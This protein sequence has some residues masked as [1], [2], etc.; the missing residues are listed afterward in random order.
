MT[1]PLNYRMNNSQD[2]KA[3][4][5]SSFG[6]YL[7]AVGDEGRSGDGN[8]A[9]AAGGSGGGE[10]NYCKETNGAGGTD[11]SNETSVPWNATCSLGAGS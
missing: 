9:D 2:S 10:G 8:L 5:T 1:A 4:G 7:S 6:S 11:G 3:D